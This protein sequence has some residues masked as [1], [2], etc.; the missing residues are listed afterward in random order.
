METFRRSLIGKKL[1]VDYYVHMDG[2]Q[3]SW[4]KKAEAISNRS[5]FSEFSRSCVREEEKFREY[6]LGYTFESEPTTNPFFIKRWQK[7]NAVL[8]KERIDSL[9][10]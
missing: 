6:W 2:I 3:Q 10:S 9:F 8:E 5:E 1:P 4:L 7:K